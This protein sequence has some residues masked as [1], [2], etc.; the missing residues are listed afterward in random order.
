MWFE[1]KIPLVHVARLAKQTLETFTIIAVRCSRDGDLDRQSIDQGA[2]SAER[3]K[4]KCIGQLLISAWLCSERGSRRLAHGQLQ[5]ALQL[6]LGRWISCVQNFNLVDLCTVVKSQVADR[7]LWTSSCMTKKVLA[8]II[9]FLA[10][11]AAINQKLNL[12]GIL[13]G[14][15]ISYRVQRNGL[16]AEQS[17][18]P[19]PAFWIDVVDVDRAQHRVH[20]TFPEAAHDSA[21]HWLGMS[22]ACPAVSTAAIYSSICRNEILTTALELRPAAGSDKADSMIMVSLPRNLLISM[23]LTQLIVLSSITQP[24][25]LTFSPLPSLLPSSI[26]THHLMTGSCVEAMPRCLIFSWEDPC[27]TRSIPACCNTLGMRE[28][29][30]HPSS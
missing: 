3:G 14:R 25:T 22:K 9:Y 28:A 1:S 5:G 26:K 19:P 15:Y 8:F 16:R 23:S 11:G 21:C 30:R 13:I 18:S 6:D 17:R 24:H 12:W 4:A 29:A 7:R 10:H 20:L 27:R 2:I